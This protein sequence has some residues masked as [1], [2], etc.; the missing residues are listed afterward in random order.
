MQ[1]VVAGFHRSGTSLLTQLLH[2]AGLFVGKDLLGAMP[3]NPYGHFEDREVLKL[4]RAILERHGTD[5]QWD[6][7]FPFFIGHDHWQ[8]MRRF[9][10]RRE[11]GHALWGFKDPRVCLFMSAWKHVL[12]DAKFVIVYRDPG[13]C[14][15]SL[16][17]RQAANYLK[18][19][20]DPAAHLRFYTEPDHGLKM[21][22]TYNRA[23]VTFARGHAG[24]CLVV[25]FDDLVAG[26]PVVAE[27]NKKWSAGLRPV[28]TREVFDPTVTSRREAPQ[29]VASPEVE[30][31]V[32]R[33]WEALESLAE[34]TAV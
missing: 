31:R 29:R 12:P 6:A 30:V 33:T 27:V 5:W 16:E 26:R 1:I 20:G 15:R 7:A 22:D 34:R 11:I 3:T 9:A 2:S 10:R 8:R 17:S 13:E 19:E 24:D 23:L 28:E 4:H 21:W 18:D 32:Q 14:V 25:P